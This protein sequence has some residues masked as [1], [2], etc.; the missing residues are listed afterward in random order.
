M[1]YGQAVDLETGEEVDLPGGLE[2]YLQLD[3]PLLQHTEDRQSSVTGIIMLDDGPMLVASRTILTSQIEGPTQGT[4][5]MGR[6]LDAT[7]VQA[8]SDQLT[9]SLAVYRI[10]DPAI[11]ADF[12]AAVTALDK[13]STFIQ[14]LD[15][16]TI[17]GYAT[18]P[19]LEGNPALIW[20]VDMPRNILAQGEISLQYFLGSLMIVGLVFMILMLILL[21][22]FVLARISSLN[23]VVNAIRRDADFSKRIT[24]PGKDELANFAGAMNQMLAA[25]A[26]AQDDLKVALKFKSQVLSNVS[27]DARTPLTVIMLRAEMLESGMFG[28]VTERQNDLIQSI[29]SSSQQLLYF[30]NNLLDMSQLEAGKLALRSRDFSPAAL[31]RDVESSLTP[32]AEKKGLTLNITGG[33]LLPEQMHG[34]PERLQQIIYNL[35]G[36]A[37]KFTDQGEVRVE[38]NRPQDH[39]WAIHVSDT[40]P[41][42]PKDAQQRLFEAFYQV[43]GSSTRQ[44]TQGVG[45]GLS[46]VKE[47]V[48][49]MDGQVTVTSEMGVGSTFTVTLPLKEVEQG[50]KSNGRLLIV[51]R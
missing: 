11:P 18:I 2:T 3:S 15:A 42:I 39:L 7:A 45:L 38:V 33:Q 35:V 23:E 6:F 24:M 5:V 41:G 31:M 16:N 28:E 34:D 27:H 49:L 10:A 25:L 26:K 36:N 9:M 29:L 19:D 4:M 13:T 20:R 32:L 37:V 44:Q 1:V 50:A 8:L 17:A 21:D 51:D 43:D 46:I 47:L 48:D 40:G 30:V 14:K 12:Q 22:R